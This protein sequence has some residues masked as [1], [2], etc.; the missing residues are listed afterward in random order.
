MFN[1][2]VNAIV[3]Q[4]IYKHITHQIFILVRDAVFIK[5]HKKNKTM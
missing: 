4:V 3:K 5:R 2:L 1:S